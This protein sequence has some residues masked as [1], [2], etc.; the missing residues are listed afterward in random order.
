MNTFLKLTIS[1]GLLILAFRLLD[2]TAFLEILSQVSTEVFISVIAINILAFTVMGI[3]WYSLA[4]TKIDSSLWAQLALY[5]KATFLNTFTPAN[6]GGDAYRLL[7]LKRGATTSGALIK[8]LLRER[9][10]GFYGFLIV[11]AIAYALI[12]LDSSKVDITAKNPYFYGVTFVFTV[13]MLTLL[14]RYFG[15]TIAFRLRQ[16][17]GRNKLPKLEKW[18]ETL[19]G[20]FSFENSLWPTSLTLL[21]IF[22]WVLSIQIL[23]QELGLLIPFLQLA[24]VATLVEL[25]RLIPLTIQGIGLRE[26]AFAYLLSFFGHNPEL[27]FVL[28]LET[29]IVLS[30]SIVICGPIGQMMMWIQARKSNI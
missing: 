19:E 14:F 2:T 21:G 15:K 27:C 8:L 20:L 12:T 11:F 13:F 29:Y 28:G 1:I 17:I 25:I 22:L 30:L 4:I 23:A 6:L 18:V 9:L 24:A 5:F 10:L 7:I 16:M 26:G 3:R